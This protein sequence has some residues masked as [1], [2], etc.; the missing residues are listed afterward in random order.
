MRNAK[1]L[2][3]LVVDVPF[4]G[5][6]VVDP[7]VQPRLAPGNGPVAGAIGLASPVDENTWLEYGYLVKTLLSG[8]ERMDMYRLRARV[9]CRELRWAAEDRHGLE[10][11]GFDRHCTHLAIVDPAGLVV[12]T[13]RIAT[14]TQP[15]M[16]DGPFAEF[17]NTRE[18]L[19]RNRHVVEIS[20]LATDPRVRNSR[21]ANGYTIADLLYKSLFNYCMARE[22]HRAYAIVSATMWRHM[23]MHGLIGAVIGP[24]RVMTDGVKA[25][26]VCV[27]WQAFDSVARDRDPGRWRWYTSW[28]ETRLVP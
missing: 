16:L 21:L 26:L 18:Q 10:R 4:S 20:R 23:R 25:G 1:P 22:M 5:R 14:S 8:A 12:A 9:F 24:F 17:M 13:A 11:D 28:Q 27:D 3:T 15:W 6:A 19:I 2:P 7:R